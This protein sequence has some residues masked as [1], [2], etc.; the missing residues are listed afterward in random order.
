MNLLGVYLGLAVLL[1]AL[2]ALNVS[3]LR[4]AEKIANGDGGNK[5]IIK[6]VRAHMNAL[7]HIL[8]YTLLL[9]F[10]YTQPVSSA[11]FAVLGFGFLLVRLLHSY[12]MLSSMFKLRQITAALTYL[13]EFTGCVF[14]L[15]F[16]VA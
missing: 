11:I 7:E 16:S 3:R 1:V 4:I 2:L 6:A 15:V 14:V 13:F 5:K 9:A 8:P 10:L 12:S